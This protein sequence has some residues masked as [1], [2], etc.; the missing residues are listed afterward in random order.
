M[1]SRTY[2][3]PELKARPITLEDA[4]RAGLQRWHLDTKSWRRLG[5]EVYVW[6]S[7]RDTPA[8]Q[9]AA[10]RVRLPPNAAFSGLTA[11]WLHG[12]DVDPCHPIEATLP[13][14]GGVS[15]RTGISIRRLWLDRRDT[16]V[17]RG[18]RA[19]T[20]ERTLADLS[21][22]LTITEAVVLADSAL[23][24]K[25]TTTKRLLEA[26]SRSHGHR[27]VVAFRRVIELCEPL[28]ESQMESRL[29]M[30]LVLAKLPRPVAQQ[31]IHDRHGRFLGRPDLYYPNQKL[32][33]EYDGGVHRTTLVED[34][35]RQN[36]LLAAGIRLLR[37]T[38][39]DIFNRPDAVVDEVRITL[40]RAGRASARG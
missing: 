33:I 23:H 19:T 30:L 28:S 24:L 11:A 18:V 9:I 13:L 35:R 10:A 25:L 3:P 20:I 16:S 38:A 40:E 29:R 32:G 22:R 5:P 4:R 36:R 39:S 2:V 34:N 21:A 31:P 26:A 27:C 6:A 8:I 17:V 7:A 14:E 12:L 37:F 15:G 1:C